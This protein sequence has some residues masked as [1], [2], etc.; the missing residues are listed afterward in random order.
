MEF[1]LNQSLET[2]EHSITIPHSDM[3]LMTYTL[4]DK[5]P[6]RMT[7]PDDL[8]ALQGTGQRVDNFTR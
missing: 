3:L 7:N 1:C 8:R 5:P 6:K 4:H 2:C